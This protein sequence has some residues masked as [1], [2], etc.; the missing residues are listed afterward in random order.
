[1]AGK[2]VIVFD[3]GKTI[4]EYDSNNWVVDELGATVLFNKLRLT[5][6][7]NSI[8]DWIMKELHEQGKT[9]QHIVEAA[10]DIGGDL[11][12]VSDANLFFVGT[13]LNHLVLRDY[14]S[15]INTNPSFVNEQ[16]RLRIL[17]SPDFSKSSPT[18][19]VIIER[20]QASVAA[21]GNKTIIYLG[22]GADDYCPSLKLSEGDFVMPRKNFPVWDW[23]SKN[24]LL[25]KAKIHEWTDG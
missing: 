23:I 24:P 4:I 18:M 11:R 22:D 21:E 17:P 15:E 13:I 10:Y 7:W 25:I 6:L 12:I 8:T 5:M 9:I 2:T 19:G 20:I 3:F 16:G 1:M 14:F